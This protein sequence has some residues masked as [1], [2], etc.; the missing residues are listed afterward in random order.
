MKSAVE[1]SSLSN[2]K[3]FRKHT[4]EDRHGRRV[5]GRD[6]VTAEA[7]EAGTWRDRRQRRR[8]GERKRRAEHERRRRKAA[9]VEASLQ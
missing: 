6:G 3:L 9:E 2:A 8:E 5:R 7:M 1:H 4:R